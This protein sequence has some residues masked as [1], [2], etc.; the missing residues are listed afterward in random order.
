M[1]LLSS[2]DR[3]DAAKWKDAEAGLE[4]AKKD[5]GEIIARFGAQWSEALPE[6]RTTQAYRS[7]DSYDELDVAIAFGVGAAIF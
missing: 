7:R 5:G 1:G 6:H 3:S 4:K 2:R